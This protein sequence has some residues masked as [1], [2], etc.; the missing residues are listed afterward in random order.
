M[1]AEVLTGKR[2]IQEVGIDA[3][4]LQERLQKANIGQVI[5]YDELSE[6]VNKDVRKEG[7]SAFLSARKACLREKIVFGTI[8]KVGIKRVSDSEIVK[9]AAAGVRRVRSAIRRE[10]IRLS[11]ANKSKLDNESKITMYTT[12][13]L[14][15][16]LDLMTQGKKISMVEKKCE[17][18]GGEIPIRQTLELFA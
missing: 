4:I 7:Y 16:A 11:C 12:A 8:A 9:G 18:I 17:H 6:I 3:K 2:T 10:S 1:Q 13:S 15:G 5:S 14:F